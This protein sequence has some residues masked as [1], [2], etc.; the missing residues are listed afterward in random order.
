MKQEPILQNKTE[1]NIGESFWRVCGAAL[2]AAAAEQ[3]ML[4]VAAYPEAESL[5]IA[6]VAR[7]Q[8]GNEGM[9]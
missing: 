9:R 7:T 2:L 4:N 5:L 1:G 8:N 3:G 6:E